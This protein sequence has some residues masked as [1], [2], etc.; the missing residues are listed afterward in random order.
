MKKFTILV[1][2]V[3]STFGAYAQYNQ[4]RML[5]GGS[6]GFSTETEKTKFDGNTQTDGKWTNFS[7]EPQFG[8]F[9]IDNLAVGASLDLGLSKWK[10]DADSDDDKT[11]TSIEIQPTVRYYLP[12][13]IFFQGQVGFGTAKSKFGSGNVDEY[14]YN[15]LSWALAAGYAYFLNDN[16]AIE[17][18]V[19]YGSVREK[20]KDSDVKYIDNG[21]F[22]RVGLQVYLGNK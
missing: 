18:M 8:Y 19:G 10:D 9:I 12:Q 13:N 21:I 16:V 5:V 14:K 20:D 6:L 7:L 22:L 17:P 3:C 1:V 4:G 11:Y 2:A 15:T